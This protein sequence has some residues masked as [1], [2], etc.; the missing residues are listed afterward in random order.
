MVDSLSIWIWGIVALDLAVAVAAICALRY[1]SGV[2]FGVD[3]LR[4]H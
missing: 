3:Q 2:L 4:K 1:G